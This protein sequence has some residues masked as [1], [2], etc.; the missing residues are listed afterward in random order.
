M[1]VTQAS[2]V[3]N[4][5]DNRSITG[6]GFQPESMWVKRDDSHKALWKPESLA[7][8]VSIRWGTQSAEADRIQA[9][10][11]DGFQI[12][13]HQNVNKDGQTYHY[14]AFRDGP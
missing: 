1:N 4:G 12:G 6:V 5:A 7:G 11:A 13:A 2:Y 14:I 8:A 10:E 3:G 9:L